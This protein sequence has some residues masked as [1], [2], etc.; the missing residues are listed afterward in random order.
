MKKEQCWH[1]GCRFGTESKPNPGN[2]YPYGTICMWLC[3]RRCIGDKSATSDTL[4]AFLQP[5]PRDPPQEKGAGLVKFLWGQS[6]R[7]WNRRNI[8]TNNQLLGFHVVNF[9]ACNLCAQTLSVINF[10]TIHWLVVE[11]THLK[12]MRKSNW[13][14]KPQGSGMKIKLKPP[15]TSTT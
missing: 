5:H 4:L 9:Q 10:P 6:L 14:M 2:Q 15:P 11:L 12:N 1:Q 3:F 13:I 8:V 7:F